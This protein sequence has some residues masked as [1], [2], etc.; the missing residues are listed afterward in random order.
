MPQR[1]GR[2]GR[3]T[4][5][6]P[7]QRLRPL[8]PVSPHGPVRRGEVRRPPTRV[9]VVAG[10]GRAAR[11]ACAPRR[12][13]P[14]WGWLLLLGLAVFAAVVGLGVLAQ[15]V[16]AASGVPEE[17][18]LVS[19][20]PGETLWEVASRY[21][22]DSEPASVV[23]RIEELNGLAGSGVSPGMAIAVPVQGGAAVSA[24]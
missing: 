15:S 1:P 22:P 24:G 19:V 5:G 21:A 8:R 6:V 20:A 18:A 10:R 14:R 12:M 4:S 2:D 11:P 3:A 7:E 13:A 17:T 16:P 9:R 23:R